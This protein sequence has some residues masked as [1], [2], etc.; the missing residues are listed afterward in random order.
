MS[1]TESNNEPNNQFK[2][3]GGIDEKGYI[4]GM[5]KKGFNGSRALSELY[6]NPLDA[7]A[8]KIVSKIDKMLFHLIHLF[9]HKKY[10]NLQKV[11][12]LLEN[13]TNDSKYCL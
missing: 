1:M 13:H 6:A 4:N 10:Y 5:N 8:S 3:A 2:M 11:Y 9:F 12:Q 7:G